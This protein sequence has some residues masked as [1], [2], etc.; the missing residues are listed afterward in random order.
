MSVSKTGHW[1]LRAILSLFFTFSS[2]CMSICPPFFSFFYVTFALSPYGT[3]P[4]PSVSINPRTA[5]WRCRLS[6]SLSV[7]VWIVLSIT[8][9]NKPNRHQF[10][11]PTFVL[12]LCTFLYYTFLYIRYKQNTRTEMSNGNDRVKVSLNLFLFKHK[13]SWGESN[14]KQL[15][16]PFASVPQ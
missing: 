4:C 8:F 13:K 15:S 6:F 1:T 10:Y 7:T 11:L 14:F 16:L 3:D 5:P 12:F 2:R 9:L